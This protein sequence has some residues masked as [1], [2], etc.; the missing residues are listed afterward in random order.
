MK[1]DL[2][3]SQK[4]EKLIQ[5]AINGGWNLH[6]DELKLWDS[7]RWLPKDRAF[8][9]ADAAIHTH[10]L[11]E[12]IF[13]HDFAKALFGEEKK[14]SPAEASMLGYSTG[15]KFDRGSNSAFQ[16]IINKGWKAHLQQAVISEDPISYM[17]KVV[18]SDE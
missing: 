9:I 11:K 1:E 16:V 5:K 18:F 10:C 6:T 8:N 7:S 15:G 13:N 12:V 2:T 14:V 3:Q 17:Y 4:L